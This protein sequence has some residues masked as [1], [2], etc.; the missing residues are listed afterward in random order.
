MC[1]PP[2]LTTLHPGVTYFHPLFGYS[3]AESLGLL[4]HDEVLQSF[5]KLVGTPWWKQD[6]QVSHMNSSAAPRSSSS[7]TNFRT[8]L[9]G[10]E[11]PIHA[12]SFDGGSRQAEMGGDE[13]GADWESLV[14]SRFVNA[15]LFPPPSGSTLEKEEEDLLAEIRE[16]AMRRAL[17]PTALPTLP[18]DSLGS[19]DRRE[20]A[21]VPGLLRFPTA[22]PYPFPDPEISCM[23]PGVVAGPQPPPPCWSPNIKSAVEIT[24]EAFGRINDDSWTH[25]EYVGKLQCGGVGDDYSLIKCGSYRSA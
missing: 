14:I 24:R 4:H 9:C 18:T 17:D 7:T 12:S 2:S 1:T 10:F 16:C 23:G 20:G 21:T 13:L 11:F 8:P 19:G 15:Q 6:S 5:D 22:Y 25:S 3:N